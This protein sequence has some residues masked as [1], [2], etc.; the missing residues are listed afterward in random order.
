MDIFTLTESEREDLRLLHY[1]HRRRGGSLWQYARNQ[2]ITAREQAAGNPWLCTQL[3][4]VPFGKFAL[5]GAEGVVQK[6]TALQ[7][8]FQDNAAGAF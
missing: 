8:S 6:L 5:Y 3:C 7:A 2:A 1:Q 4:R